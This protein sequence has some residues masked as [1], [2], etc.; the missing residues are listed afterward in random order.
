LAPVPEHN[1][2]VGFDKLNGVF[3]VYHE[4]CFHHEHHD[5]VIMG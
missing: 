5:D 1:D 4:F 3:D 2:N